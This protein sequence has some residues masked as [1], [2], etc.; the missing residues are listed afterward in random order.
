MILQILLV[1]TSFMAF[2][3]QAD[4]IRC[5]QSPEQEEQVEFTLKKNDSGKYDLIWSVGYKKPVSYALAKDLSCVFQDFYADCK[6]AEGDE[7][8]YSGTVEFYRS[9]FTGM[10]SLKQKTASNI[11]SVVY[12]LIRTRIHHTLKG[13]LS[14]EPYTI[15]LKGAKPDLCE[16]LP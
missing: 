14:I 16:V 8:L 12:I 13:F 15:R 5:V 11:Q 6:T 1:L 10:S 3:A 7:S 4:G 2:Q 9:D